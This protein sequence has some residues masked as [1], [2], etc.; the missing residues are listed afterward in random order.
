MSNPTSVTVNVPATTANIGPGFDCLGAALT[1]YNQFTFALVEGISEVEITV[2]GEEAEKIT[3]DKTNLAYVAFLEFYRH[4]DKKPPNNLKCDIELGFPLAR[5]LGSSAT[6]IVGGLV[7]ANYLGGNL[8][9]LSEIINL[10]IAIEGHP[11]NVVP[12]ILGNCQLSV[13]RGDKWEI[14][15]VAWHQDIIPVIAIP[16]RALS[17]KEARSILPDRLD[18]SDAI[19]NISRLGMLLQGLQHNRA[20]WLT[21]ALEDRLH[22]PYRQ[23][24]ITGY[25]A[26]KAAAL[27]A[28]A[29]GTVISGAGPSLLAL[30]NLMQAKAVT[31]AMK[32][33]WGDRGVKA[34]VKPLMLD[35]S[36]M[37]L[38]LPSRDARDSHIDS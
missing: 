26:V 30:T 3:T 7:A 35:N 15:Q 16:D 19:F 20:D 14:C 38:N 36:G 6:A 5:G 13:G 28:G 24:L 8:L 2:K 4:L 10:A 9:D 32:M 23:I 34:I 11:D 18:R 29:Y 33:A 22:Q 25:E 31:S 17:T 1:I 21:I 37:K 27:A 12:A